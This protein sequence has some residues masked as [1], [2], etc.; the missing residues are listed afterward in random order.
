MP[1]YLEPLNPEQLAAV[2][3]EGRS[4][5]ILAG[6]GS[7][8][9]RVITTKIAWLIREKGYEPESI[10]AVTFTNKAAREMA[11]RAR[12]IESRCERTMIRTFHSF[13]AWFLRRNAAA[14]GLRSDFAIYDDDDQATL[15][16]AMEGDGQL[17]DAQTLAR[18]VSRAKDKAMAP[19]HPE[20]EREFTE[21][22]FRR[23]Y[24]EYEKR[25]RATGN[26]DFGDLILLPARALEADE[27]LRR[28]F[29]QRFRVIL[30]DEYQDTNVAQYELLRALA[31]PDTYVCVVGDD[32]QSIYRFR[33][34]EIRNILSFPETFP[35]TEVVRLTRNY[36]SHQAILDVAG[37]VV[38]KNSGRLGK[39]LVAVKEGGPKPTVAVLADADE[40]A[41][42]CSR[43]AERRARSGG[44]WS[45]V[46]ILYRNNA[47][48][49]AFEKFFARRG[50]PYRIV[51]SVRFYEREE[52][53]DVLAWLQLASNPRDE[54]A[55]RRVVNK[56][57]RGIGDTSLDCIVEAATETTGDLVAAAEAARDTLKSAKTRNGV[58]AFV[59]MARGFSELLGSGAPS[60]APGADPFDPAG[61]SPRLDS[62]LPK[63]SVV[64]ERVAKDS[65]LVEYHKAQ[66]AVAA[67]QKVANID[68]LVNAA[69][70]WP[71]NREGLAAFLETI[72]LD[73]RM[74]DADEASD[75][76][77]L[78]TMHNTKGLEFPCV[79]VTGLEQGLF[80]RE[81]DSGEDLEEQ[82][83]LFYVAATRAKDELHLVCCRRR[84]YRGRP[85]EN[86]PSIFLGEIGKG[87]Y[88]TVGGALH[89]GA[90]SAAAGPWKPGLA[91]YHDDHG[92]G[93]VTAVKAAGE[94]GVVVSVRF[95]TGR[96]LQFF[97]KY[98]SKLEILGKGQ[99]GSWTSC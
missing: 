87:L 31:G 58:A 3:H 19:D 10:L 45:D 63:L 67:T 1:A 22:A 16:K 29:R 66:D 43:V 71:A 23:R 78:I 37:S 54:V 48:S 97:P 65:G 24:A 95:E 52:V 70:D 93:F 28:R 38:A 68:E 75:A 35:G 77:T 40:E 42:Y 56:P 17:R 14:L 2:T 49:L 91:V 53:K 62:S 69:A 82:R 99:G 32:D 27:A 36:R 90:L 44:S 74:A 9:T 84:L 85:M 21:R 98:T 47:Q 46:A 76:V 8:K 55:F 25:L 51:G 81:D 60:L 88:E 6:A 79:I 20:L 96:V 57:S 92:S 73:R 61:D 26:V 72:E 15:V 18:A 86:P 12:S 13:G 4:L 59:A 30:V 94:A 5:L 33:G 83:R 39:D 64:V 11:E 80:P 34:A 50:I 89:A 41:P 7:G